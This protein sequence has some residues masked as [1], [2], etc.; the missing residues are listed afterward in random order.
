VFI[1]KSDLSR[2]DGC[3]GILVDPRGKEECDFARGLVIALNSGFE[4]QVGY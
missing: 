1:Y 2:G 3:H 4:G